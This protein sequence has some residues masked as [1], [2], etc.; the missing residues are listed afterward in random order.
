[1]K[2]AITCLGIFLFVFASC[3][4][5]NT[6]KPT[7]NTAEQ[8]DQARILDLLKKNQCSTCHKVAD[9]LI[10]PSY[11]D[12]AARKYSQERIIQLIYKPEPQNW[13]GYPPMLPM[14]NVPMEDAKEIADWIISLQ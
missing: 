7:D 14:N 10:G 4:S 2:T 12:I 11:Q 6:N 1:M 8:Q 13:E 5:N 9:K 3:S